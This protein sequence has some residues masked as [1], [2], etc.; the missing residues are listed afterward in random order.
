L[1]AFWEGMLAG[2]GV[3]IPI[4]AIAI[5]ILETSIR[6]GFLSGFVAGAGVALADTVYALVASIAGIVVASALSPYASTLRMISSIILLS[7]GSIGLYRTLKRRNSEPRKGALAGQTYTRTFWQ[8]L[9]LTLLNP[10][11]VVYF[12]ALIMNR[13]TSITPSPMDQLVFI[14]GAGLASLSWQTLLASA[15]HFARHI[16]SGKVQ[17]IVSIFGYL[18]VFSLGLRILLSLKA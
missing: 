12:T 18:I 13:E 16:L 11:T 9:G 6:R 5:L 8:F 10:L 17:V 2:Y 1:S 15:G 7:I 3:A 14:I 4:G